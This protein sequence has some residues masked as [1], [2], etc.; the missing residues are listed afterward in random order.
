MTEGNGA[1]YGIDNVEW[2]LEVLDGHDRL[3]SE[4]F[5]D[6]EKVHVVFGDSRLLK[7]L[8]DSECGSNT[9]HQQTLYARE[10]RLTP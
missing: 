5:I 8:W 7:D 1:S 10:G 2:D 9:A 4:S 3:T 6:L